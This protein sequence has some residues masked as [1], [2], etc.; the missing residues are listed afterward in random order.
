MPAPSARG[1]SAARV[2]GVNA[3]ELDGLIELEF[4]RLICD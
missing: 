4:I 3:R 2:V 1:A